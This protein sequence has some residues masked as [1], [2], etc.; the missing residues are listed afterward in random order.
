MFE[1]HSESGYRLM[2]EGVEQKT[3]VYG[4]KTLM[5][6]FVLKRGSTMPPHAHPH[7]QT[8]YLVE[9]RLH[10]WIGTEKR[11]TR[12]GDSWC[13][14]GGVEHRVDIMEDSVAIEVFSPVREDYLPKKEKQ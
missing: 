11:E 5:A 8:G 4:D 12:A 2:L 9:G 14:P 13:I 10:F 3:L 7:E 1:K 6:K